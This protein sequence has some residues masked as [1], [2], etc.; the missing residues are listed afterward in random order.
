MPKKYLPLV[1]PNIA[2]QYALEACSLN[3]E[4][5]KV[6]FNLSNVVLISQIAYEV[7]HYYWYMKDEKNDQKW[8][9]VGVKCP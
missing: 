5:E 1:F 4:V 9:H 3:L 7:S 2:I 8:M 6:T